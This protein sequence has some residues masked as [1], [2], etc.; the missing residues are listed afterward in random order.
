[1]RNNVQRPVVS[2]LRDDTMTWPEVE[3]MIITSYY[4]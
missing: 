2:Q 4:R 3:G 1:M